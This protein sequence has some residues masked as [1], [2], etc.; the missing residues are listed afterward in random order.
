MGN[1]MSAS[2]AEECT[3]LKKEYDTCFNDWY[4]NK[5]LK[6]QSLHNECEDLWNNYITCVNTALAQHKIKA[7]L[8]KARE[9]Q[10]FKEE[11]K[12]K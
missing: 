7:L 10:P 11:E 1:A 5:F 2:F 8:D 12:K 3:P 4:L 6:G 9:D